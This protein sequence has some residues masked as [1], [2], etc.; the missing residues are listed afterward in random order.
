VTFEGS[1]RVKKSSGEG[2]L[3][4]RAQIQA[5]WHIYSLTQ[6]PGGPM[7][8]EIS[9]PP[10]P[11][12][13]ITGKFTADRDPYV[14]TDEV[15]P[16]V[17][18]EEFADEVVF[19]A[20]LKLNE[21]VDPEALKIA[22]TVNGQVCE[23]GGACEL[24]ENEIVEASFDTY[25]DEAIPSGTFFEEGSAIKI[26]G[27]LEPKTASPG[28]VVDLKL[29]ADLDE[30]W[31]VY[32]YG[33]QKIEGTIACP[34]LIVI[35]K[36]SGFDVGT[37][38]PSAPPTEKESGIEEE[39]I[40]RYH[41][42]SV[43]WT[44]PITIPDDTKPGEY[45]IAG[46]IAYQT[47]TDTSCDNPKAL[48]FA[49]KFNV[50]ESGTP[51]QVPLVYE[52][53]NYDAVAKL[54][55]TQAAQQS[56]AS[57]TAAT[58]QGKW[59]EYSVFTVLGF[60]FLAGLILNVMPCVLPVI[61]L[62]I[63]SFVQQAGGDRWEIFSLNA[64]FSLGLLTV[65][66][67]LA[68]LAAFLQMGW[69]EHFGNVWFTV[70]MISVVFAFGLSFLGVW[71]IPIPGFV[72]T[73]GMQKAAEREGAAG[74]FSK[75]ILTTI[76]ATPCAGPL[77]VP[78]VNWAIAQ[79]AW[80]TYTAFTAMGLGMAAPYLL[81]GVF[82]ALI[83]W[84]PKPGAWMDTFK[85]LMGFL[86]MGTVV[87]LFNSLSEDSVIPTLTLLVGIGI[88]CWWWGRT[89]ITA[90]TR[91]RLWSYFQGAVVVLLAALLGFYGLVSRHELDWQP[92]SRV[93]LEEHLD[94][95]RTVLVDFTADW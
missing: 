11:D 53:G 49:A 38:Q 24:I 6:P 79:P 5:N 63:M 34:T 66:W 55:A 12:F 31:H 45:E 47:C 60:A 54:A 43:T 32:A 37:P 70:T 88:A 36:S 46:S 56:K 7:R 64:V 72:T 1:F 13:D 44:V 65:F 74:A 62:K 19:S 9:V 40:L 17:N 91:E 61:G 84:L 29:Q 92:F 50:G 69:G 3:Q 41:K 14:H 67:I 39:P 93:V 71:E 94:Q 58:N 35:R 76:L 16:G 95:G 27:F 73:P 48:Q 90:E 85:Q 80:L 10:S 86:L 82:P 2:Q 87:F 18:V 42:D 89:P 51:G 26:T 25:I 22:V 81:I 8:T 20:P 33:P 77:L 52:T 21:G 23:T 15:F 68:T 30:G 78:A 75:G 57:A 28:S 59:S 83:N 4:V